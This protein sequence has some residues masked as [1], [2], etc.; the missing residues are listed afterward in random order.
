MI[1]LNEGEKGFMSVF[2]SILTILFV[3][4]IFS[5]CAGT[6]SDNFHHFPSPPVVLR[7]P[8]PRS[9]QLVSVPFDIIERVGFEYGVKARWYRFEVTGTS[10]IDLGLQVFGK[11]NDLA[12]EIRDSSYTILETKTVRSGERGNIKRAVSPGTYEIRVYIY[13]DSRTE[14]YKLSCTTIKNKLETSNIADSK[15]ISLGEEIKDS[16]GDVNGLK[17]RWYS[18]YIDNSKEVNITLDSSDRGEDIDLFLANAA[19]KEIKSSA[20]SG[21]SEHITE[22]LDRGFY[23]IRVYASKDNDGCQFSLKLSSVGAGKDYYSDTKKILE[24]Y[25]QSAIKMSDDN[26]LTGSVGAGNKLRNIWYKVE[27]EKKRKMKLFFKPK[28][29]RNL[30]VRIEDTSGKVIDEK[31]SV[32][33]ELQ[34]LTYNLAPGEYFIQI[35]SEKSEGDSFSI[36]IKMDPGAG[37]TRVSK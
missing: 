20:G 7:D 36:K 14:S 11:D 18:F 25:R 8:G 31:K 10:D 23:Y 16:V 21:A 4:F 24:S 19:G 35:F 9:S 1:S 30:N 28:S 17:D 33:P 37:F 5:G 15:A 27:V 12:I 22:R 2:K 29:T 26:E 3:S 34:V 13:D 32:D 6:S